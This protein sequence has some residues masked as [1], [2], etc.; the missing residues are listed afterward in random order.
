MLIIWAGNWVVVFK[1]KVTMRA[2]DYHENITVLTVS[3][4]VRSLLQ[5]NIVW[6]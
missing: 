4:E 1:V 2:Y 3:S 6:W 5:S